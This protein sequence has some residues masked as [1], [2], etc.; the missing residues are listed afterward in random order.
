MNGFF[1]TS[2][3]QQNLH[4]L[5]EIF[6]GLQELLLFSFFIL[7]SF[8]L[9]RLVEASVFKRHLMLGFGDELFK[10]QDDR[11][12]QARIIFITNFSCLRA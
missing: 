4:C 11:K 10:N 1:S 5:C 8:L 3:H 6:P 9:L 7:D 12:V 2:H